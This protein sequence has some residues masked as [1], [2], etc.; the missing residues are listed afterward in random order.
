[1]C[2]CVREKE[3]E[4]EITMKTKIIIKVYLALNKQSLYRNW[5]CW[6]IPHDKELMAGS[7]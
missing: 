2:V 4:R 6:R 1:M 3:K 5:T 7:G